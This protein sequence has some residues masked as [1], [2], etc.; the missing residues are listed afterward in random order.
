LD[1][2][3]LSICALFNGAEDFQEIEDFGRQRMG[4]LRTF[5][6]L[7]NGIPSHD[8][9]R[10]VFLR[11]DNQVFNEK[12]MAW[13]RD[14]LTGLGLPFKHISIDGKTLR[15][16]HT[17]LHLVH[18]VASELGVCLGQAKTD[19]K[20]NEITA[21]PN[22]LDMLN[23]KGCIVSLDAMGTQKEIAKQIVGKGGDYFLA[24]KGNQKTLLEQVGQQF[25][26]EKADSYFEVQDFVGSHNAVTSY[27]IGVC[28]GPKWV[29]NASEWTN[30]HSV[31]QIKSKSN[32]GQPDVRYYISSIA[33]LEAEQAASLARGHWSV[34]NK[35]HWQ[36][37]VT[38]RE[39]GKRNRKDASAENLSL[40]RKI[41]LNVV[42]TH[43][44]KMSK[45]RIIKK[46]I[47]NPEYC[48]Q[49]LAKII[50]I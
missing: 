18:A 15:G 30:L 23:L 48:L 21:I 40:L 10:R 37:D 34:E 27:Q 33:K 12:F 35:L 7:P 3:L 44:P 45:K 46:M 19:E 16:A 32:K 26:L 17:N 50:A 39:D 5:L 42:Q 1:I 36:L 29:E 6:S 24:L 4:F 49:M 9:I 25:S 28:H 38:L 8:T 20:S 43:E 14:L 11:L 47:W 22:L 2:L 31:V 41:L 13:V